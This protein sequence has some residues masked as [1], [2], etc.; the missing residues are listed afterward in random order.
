MVCEAVY[1][2]DKLLRKNFEYF[3]ISSVYVSKIPD[4]VPITSFFIFYVVQCSCK[5]IENETHIC[6]VQISESLVRTVYRGCV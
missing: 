2:R 4:K 1:G 3:L 6:F 5:C